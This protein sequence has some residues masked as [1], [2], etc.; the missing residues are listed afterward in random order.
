MKYV[1]AP[2]KGRSYI[3]TV[4]V[5]A[6]TGQLL[7]EQQIEGAG[8]QQLDLGHLEAGTYYLRLEGTG[9]SRLLKR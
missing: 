9:S 2:V 8:V 5:H 7:A 4:M 3:Y 6:E 1:I